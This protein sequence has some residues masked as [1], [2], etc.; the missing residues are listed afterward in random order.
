MVYP[1][2]SEEKLNSETEKYPDNLKGYTITVGDNSYDVDSLKRYVQTDDVV[3]DT[4][5]GYASMAVSFPA[6]K[7]H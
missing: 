5:T 3:F 1:D 4:E 7:T 6:L 2:I